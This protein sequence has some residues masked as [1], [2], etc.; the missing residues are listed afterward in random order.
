[1]K[2][3]VVSEADRP[4][5]C[6]CNGELYLALEMEMENLSLTD[7]Y[8]VQPVPWRQGVNAR[9]AG[10]LKS[11]FMRSANRGAR[12][13]KRHHRRHCESAPISLSSLATPNTFCRSGPPCYRQTKPRTW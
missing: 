9:D 12:A 5:K 1:M 8:Q 13:G 2:Y 6:Q 7:G 3:L 4:I 10:R 11:R